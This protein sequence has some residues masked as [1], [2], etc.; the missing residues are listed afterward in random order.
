MKK[1]EV[2]VR[3]NNNIIGKGIGKTKKEAEQ[4]AAEE[5]CRLFE[6]SC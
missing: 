1:F 2:E 6:I 4:N 5:A 3:L